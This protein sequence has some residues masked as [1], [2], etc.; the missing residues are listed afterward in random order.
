MRMRRRA[1]KEGGFAAG[2]GKKQIPF[3]DDKQRKLQPKKETTTKETKA[4]QSQA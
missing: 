3:G 4:M 2:R 1:R